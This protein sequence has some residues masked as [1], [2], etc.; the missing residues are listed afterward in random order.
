MTNIQ[1]QINKAVSYLQDQQANYKQT[2][3]LSVTM[4][5]NDDSIVLYFDTKQAGFTVALDAEFYG[6][7]VITLS[8]D[9]IYV[10][11]DNGL[12]T[13]SGEGQSE[14]LLECKKLVH[15]AVYFNLADDITTDFYNE[16]YA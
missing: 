2:G 12:E 11:T 15:D 13:A 6:N 9:E 3:S 8:V 14:L 5:V 10:D 1:A 7:E 16:V 4:D